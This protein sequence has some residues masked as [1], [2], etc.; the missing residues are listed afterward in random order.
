MEIVNELVDVRLQVFLI[1]PYVLV[2]HMISF[3]HSST[4]GLK[5]LEA[6]KLII[7]GQ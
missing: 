3:E 6:A 2:M 7:E 1:K 5:K 4:H